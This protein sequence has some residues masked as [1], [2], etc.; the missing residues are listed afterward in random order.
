MSYQRRITIFGLAIFVAVAL[1]TAY[2]FVYQFE[3]FPAVT[4]LL[5]N[6]L[7]IITASLTFSGTLLILLHY[8]PTD[9]PFSIWLHF[10]FGVGLWLLGEIAW[11]WYA[12]NLDAWG[13]EQVPTPGIPDLFYILGMFM[14]SVGL[15]WLFRQRR[16]P[17][18]THR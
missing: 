7:I 13:L 9:K 2:I 6:L 8:H 11:A 16:R 4:D 17:W 12:L 3:P 10:T 15:R 5:T 1:L 14:F 18:L